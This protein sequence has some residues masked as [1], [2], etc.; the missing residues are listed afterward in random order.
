MKYAKFNIIFLA[1]VSVFLAAGLILGFFTKKPG[2]IFVKN[3][4]DLQKLIAGKET[5]DFDADGLKDWEENLWQTDPQ[6]PDTDR[7]GASDGDEVKENRDPLVPGPNDL[8]TPMENLSKN[9]GLTE[10]STLTAKIGI[11]TLNIIYQAME[12]GDLNKN[13]LKAI[14]N[15]F[16]TLVQRTK[17]SVSQYALSDLSLSKNS[18]DES[19]KKYANEFGA[20]IKNNFDEL[21]ESEL[22]ILTKY[23]TE[24]NKKYLEEIGEIAIA[25]Q[26][27]FELGKNIQT[28]EILSEKHL[29]VLN[30]FARIADELKDFK[31]SDSDPMAA[32]SALKYYQTDALDAYESLVKI[33]AYFKERGISFGDKEPAKIFAFYNN[34]E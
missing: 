31:K 10:P 22:A 6:N 15:D 26:K 3:N 21:N 12:D 25:Y 14:T 1:V 8:L 9:P 24:Q 29:I 16:D 5:A 4:P 33:N 34:Y 27:V 17:I 30:A 18:S 28:P 32:I 7:D 19:I 23:A 2:F 13:E 11:P 20:L